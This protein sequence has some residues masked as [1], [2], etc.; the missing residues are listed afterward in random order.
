MTVFN[1]L[2][3]GLIQADLGA[4]SLPRSCSPLPALTA[5][6]DDRLKL[7]W[8]RKLLLGMH[9][10]PYSPRAAVIAKGPLRPGSD[11]GCHT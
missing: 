10:A 5:D 1:S 7:V 11:Y 8:V 4:W 3:L 6:R 2:P 9:P